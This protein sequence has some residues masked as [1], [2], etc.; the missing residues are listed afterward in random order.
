MKK[1]KIKIIIK[2]AINLIPGI[3]HE[4]IDCVNLCLEF[5]PSPLQHPKKLLFDFSDK[6]LGELCQEIKR[7]TKKNK[8][9]Q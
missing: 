2:A 4:F 7:S 8:Q 9:V 1:I 6:I 3:G 5:L